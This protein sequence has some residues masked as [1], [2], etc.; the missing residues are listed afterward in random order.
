[1]SCS[2]VAATSRA[3]RPAHRADS[4]WVLHTPLNIVVLMSTRQTQHTLMTSHSSCTGR[5]FHA[6]RAYV[7]DEDGALDV[8]RFRCDAAASAE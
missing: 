4:G 5:R 2:P 3:V 6:Y 8:W 1:M 7:T